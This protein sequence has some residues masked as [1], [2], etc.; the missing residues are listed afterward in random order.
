MTLAID[1][2]VTCCRTSPRA[3]VDRNR[4]DRIVR[5]EFVDSCARE[6]ASV[7]HGHTGVVRIRRLSVKLAFARRQLG[8]AAFGRQWAATFAASLKRAL[9]LPDGAGPLEL[10]RFESRADWLAAAVAAVLQGDAATRWEFAELTWLASVSLAEAV[11][12]ILDLDFG[13]SATILLRLHARGRLDAL[14]ISIDEAALAQ[15]MQRLDAELVAAA[16]LSADNLIEIAG[17]IVQHTAPFGAERLISRR[18]ALSLWAALA[19]GQY[20]HWTPRRLSDALH[21]LDILIGVFIAHSSES[22]ATR[23]LRR[24]EDDAVGD[25]TRTP[26]GHVL[27]MIAASVED[28]RRARDALARLTATL[29]QLAQVFPLAATAGQRIVSEAAGVLL[30][31]PSVLR[32]GWPQAVQTTVLWGHHGSRTLAYLLLGVGQELLTNDE[33]GRVDPAIAVFAGWMGEPNVAG[34]RRFRDNVTP[35]ECWELSQTLGLSLPGTPAPDWSAVISAAAD[36]LVGEFASRIRGFGKSSRRFVVQ[37]LLMV[38]GEIVIEER[39]LQ[40]ALASCPFHVALHVSSMFETVGAVSWLGF[41]D[42]VFRPGGA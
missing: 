31:I 14:L 15:L 20:G 17:R 9:A 36:R 39:R 37:K 40:V 27:R 24:I 25:N 35:E 34:Y 4:I 6:L 26:L 33:R 21:S 10:R 41:R 11:N 12:R 19:D 23:L 7:F 30:L 5:T 18:R 38:A 16:P 29:T 22:F 13:N 3:D 32:L 42:L 8:E 28:D 2:F 1:H